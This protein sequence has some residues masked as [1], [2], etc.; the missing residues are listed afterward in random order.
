MMDI[1]KAE[2]G[3]REAILLPR[4]PRARWETGSEGRGNS[5]LGSCS[6]GATG[7]AAERRRLWE[8]CV[9]RDCQVL[10]EE[11][12]WGWGS[13]L[14][15]AGVWTA[16]WAWTPGRS[17]GSRQREKAMS[18]VVR[19]QESWTQVTG[20]RGPCTCLKQ[21]GPAGPGLLD[22]HQSRQQNEGPLFVECHKV[23]QGDRNNNKTKEQPRHS[24]YMSCE[25]QDQTPVTKR[26]RAICYQKKKGC[27]RV[28]LSCKEFKR[29]SSLK[30]SHTV[31]EFHI[32]L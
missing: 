26:I 3:C 14:F 30:Q 19:T 12:G 9:L 6:S 25:N 11:P 18:T 5:D 15:R 16:G 29:E 2:E 4:V 17:A 7:L 13:V 28:T 32:K 1:R 20:C 10:D 8:S 21:S 22:T 23:A 27:S 24:F 31:S